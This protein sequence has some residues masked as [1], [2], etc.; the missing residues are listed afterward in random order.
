MDIKKYAKLIA[1]ATFLAPVAYGSVLISFFSDEELENKVVNRP[2]WFIDGDF[3]QTFNSEEG[4][5]NR[6]LEIKNCSEEPVIEAISLLGYKSGLLRINLTL[7]PEAKEAMTKAAKRHGLVFK[8][9]LSSDTTLSIIASTE[10][11]SVI[12]TLAGKM[13]PLSEEA[14]AVL[15]D[16]LDSTLYGDTE[17]EA[18]RVYGSCWFIDGDFY[19]TS[20]SKEGRPNRELEIRNCSEEPV[21]EAILLLGYESGSLRIHLTLNPEAK[22]EAKKAMTKAAKKHGLVFEHSSSFGTLFNIKAS[23]EQLSVI[24]TL[25]DKIDPLSED[26][27]AILEDALGFP[28]AYKIEALNGPDKVDRTAIITEVLYQNATSSRG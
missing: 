10:Q 18:K 23:A 8:R 28:L 26:A 21:I 3:Y 7:N 11:L 14:V 15:T 2:C 19:K 27:I 4:W 13:D 25:A 20:N 16:A 5:P 6:R 22:E 12:L 24:L 17:L 1:L 9:F